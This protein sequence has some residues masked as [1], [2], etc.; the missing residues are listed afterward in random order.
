M[1]DGHIGCNIGRWGRFGYVIAL[2]SVL[3]LRM[4]PEQMRVWQAAEALCGEV[5]EL[6]PEVRSRARDAGDH[7]ER[8]SNSVLFNTAEGAGAYRPKVKINA[9]EVAKKEANEVRAVLRRLVIKKVLQDY[10][11][12]RAYNLASAI[13][14]MLTKAIITLQHRDT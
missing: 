8:S 14:A 12:R 2:S 6:L 1:G 9:Y 11:I 10:Q 4:R 3:S 5:D 7:L 13:I